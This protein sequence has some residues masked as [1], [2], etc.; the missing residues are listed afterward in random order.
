MLLQ[1]NSTQLVVGSGC[2]SYEASSVRRT[3]DFNKFAFVVL[4][5]NFDVHFSFTAW[6]VLDEVWTIIL[7]NNFGVNFTLVIIITDFDL[8]GVTTGFTVFTVVVSCLDQERSWL[9]GALV[10]KKTCSVTERLYSSGVH[11]ESVGLPGGCQVFWA[12][13]QLYYAFKAGGELSKVW[14][15]TGQGGCVNVNGYLRH[16]KLCRLWD[17]TGSAGE[18]NIDSAIITETLSSNCDSI[19]SWKLAERGVNFSNSVGWSNDLAHVQGVHVAKP[20]IVPATE[21]DKLVLIINHSG[22]LTRAWHNS[23]ALR[24]DELPFECW[25]VKDGSAVD[26]LTDGPCSTLSKVGCLTS[27]DEELPRRDG[28]N[29][30]AR[31]VPAGRAHINIW[32]RPFLS[33]KIKVHQVVELSLRVP[34][35]KGI[36]FIIRN[37][38][39]V[40]SATLRGWGL[41]ILHLFILLPGLSLNVKAVDVIEGD[42]LVAKTSMSTKDVHFAVVEAVA[43]ICAGGWGSDCWV[44][45][46]IN[47]FVTVATSPFALTSLGVEPPAVV[48]TPGWA[49]MASID[50]D[51][52]RLGRIDCHVLGSGDWLFAFD[53]FLRP[54]GLSCSNY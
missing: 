6:C 38:D 50:E 35:S 43:A 34:S 19:A 20:A 53:H 30:H 46:G 45:V 36:E 48:K 16:R 29:K 37:E 40:T 4:E 51:W 15:L 1:R 3:S 13:L 11:E 14:S 5:L 44:L 54:L 8:E 18:E 9:V 42:S 12:E 7:I 39:A 10:L 32:V 28:F 23:R 47:I 26:Y 24:L 27:K 41:G 33:L 25:E 52:L 49:S 17:G 2:S 21:D 22:V 31:M